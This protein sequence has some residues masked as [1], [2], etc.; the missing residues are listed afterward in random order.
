MASSTTKTIALDESTLLSR[1]DVA[2][3]FHIGL[4]SL[5]TLETYKRL[6]RIKIGRHTFFYKE[7]VMDFIMSHR[8][9][10]ENE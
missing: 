1:K 8:T 6:K 9:G 5:D 2:N 4:S 10:G 3:I 7:D